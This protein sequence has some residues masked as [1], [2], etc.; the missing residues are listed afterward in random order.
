[1]LPDAAP[2]GC[3]REH[4]RPVLAAACG[5]L[6]A[7]GYTVGLH[8]VANVDQRGPRVEASCRALPCGH[9][10]S[11]NGDA[12]RGALQAGRRPFVEGGAAALRSEPV[13]VGFTNCKAYSSPF[14]ISGAIPASDRSRPLRSAAIVSIWL[15][16]AVCSMRSPLARITRRYFRCQPFV[17]PLSSMAKSASRNWAKLALVSA[18]ISPRALSQ[19]SSNFPEHHRYPHCNTPYRIHHNPTPP[20]SST[21]PTGGTERECE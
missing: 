18:K 12:I 19:S 21:Q 20:R 7:G 10:P 9:C 4:G 8:G 11:F 14:T 16:P 1:M 13:P 2:V 5:M 6:V 3:C 17:S 15:Y